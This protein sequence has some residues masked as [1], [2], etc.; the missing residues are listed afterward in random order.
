[1]AKKKTTIKAFWL[2]QKNIRGIGNAYADEILWKSGIHAESKCHKIP[3]DKIK[4][5]AKEIKSV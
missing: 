1:L 4:T 2:D 5:M 3:D